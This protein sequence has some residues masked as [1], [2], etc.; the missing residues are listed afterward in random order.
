V[1]GRWNILLLPG[2]GVT[3]RQKRLLFCRLAGFDALAPGQFGVEFYVEQDGDVEDPQ[4]HR[5]ADHSAQRGL[6]RRVLGGPGW[7]R[8]IGAML[9]FGKTFA[10]RVL[11]LAA[12]LELRVFALKG[13]G[14]CRQWKGAGGWWRTF[15]L[16]GDNGTQ[17]RGI[18]T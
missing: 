2:T 17:E 12:A 10:M 15:T 16:S 5:K 6:A 4:P 1:R 14:T 7:R 3:G 11:V 8:L 13:T 9:R 18:T